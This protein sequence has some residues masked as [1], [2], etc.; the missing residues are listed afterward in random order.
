MGKVLKELNMLEKFELEI[1]VLESKNF[2]LSPSDVS[3]K[4]IINNLVEYY[5]GYLSDHKKH[6]INLI[7]SIPESGQEFIHID[8]ARLTQILMNLIDNAIKFTRK[9]TV[10]FGYKFPIPYMIQFFV[11]DTGIGIEDDKMEVI[12]KPFRQGH[13]SIAREF[14]G[15]G[16]GLTISKILIKRMGGN[17]W[18]EFPEEDKGTF[19]EL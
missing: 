13:E 16:L 7:P 19:I 6:I 3:V 1:A 14:G 11:K 18:I 9:G 8:G 4:D 2:D 12:F 5:K 10:E 15:S 17:I